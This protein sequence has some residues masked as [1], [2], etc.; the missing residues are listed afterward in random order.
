MLDNLQISK[1][2]FTLAAGEKGLEL[3]PFKSSAFRGG[4]GHVFKDLTCA[5]PGKNCAE[6]SIQDS[7][8]YI[9]VFETQPPTN[10]KVSPKFES[11]PRPYVICTE[12]DGKRF[13]KPNET[14]DFELLIFGDAFSYVPFFIHS[15]EVLGKKG[16]G[17]ER[18]PYS[19][20]RVEVIDLS[21]GTSYLVYEGTQKQ[22]RHR[23]VIF[24]G[25][26]LLSRAEKIKET[27][28]TVTFDTPLRMKY[29]GNYTADPQF[30]LL[31]RN[32]LRRVTSLLYFHHG[33]QEISLDVPELIRKAEQ[34][35]LVKST[36]RWVD[37]ERYSARQDT[38]MS[39]GG[40]MGEATYEG[41]LSEFVPW[42]LA[43]E[44]LGIGK[45]TVF[46]LG[47]MRL[48]WGK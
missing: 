27:A 22:I 25:K 45:Q 23:E 7:C 11:V 12:F 29:Q 34:V 3:P 35:Q 46:G 14:V 2:R 5:F 21:N 40:I 28:V 30:H 47:R 36:A 38:K 26:E 16:I 8:P 15:F 48:I 42:L 1:Y 19:L 24:T 20:H 31:I 18:K 9:Y 17:K 6:C 37:W 33:G 4:F 44:A 41:E 10:S 43:A 39:F 13:Y 32:A